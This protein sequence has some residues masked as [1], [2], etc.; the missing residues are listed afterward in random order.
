MKIKFNSDDDLPLNK[1]LK[2]L[3]L[4]IIVRTVFEEDCKYY[5]QIFLDECLYELQKCYSMKEL[6]SLKELILITQINQ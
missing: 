4:V 2:F 3:D 6:M 1:Q 5:P